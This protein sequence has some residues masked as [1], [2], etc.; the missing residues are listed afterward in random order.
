[1]CTCVCVLI[2]LRCCVLMLWLVGAG[3]VNINYINESVISVAVMRR[4][5]THTHTHTCRA[6]R[7]RAVW[8]RCLLC[9]YKAR[10]LGV[11]RWETGEWLVNE[12]EVSLFWLC[13]I[14]VSQSDKRRINRQQTHH[15]HVPLV[16]QLRRCQE[17]KWHALKTK[18]ARLAFSLR[19][20]E[21]WR[22]H[23]QPLSV[24]SSPL[25]PR[26]KPR[27]HWVS[28]SSSLPCYFP[29]PSQFP[30]LTS[31]ILTPVVWNQRFRIIWPLMGAPGS[32]G[33]LL[34]T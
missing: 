29:S 4:K 28:H 6:N 2:S 32:Q 11:H 7:E 17:L 27:F 21:V 16:N 10:P 14:T 13:T 19:G 22:L 3:S 12:W 31:S 23:I 33:C 24:P 5:R 15:S 34:S 9:F 18:T 25:N 26:P 20:Y 1:M 30:P 8:G